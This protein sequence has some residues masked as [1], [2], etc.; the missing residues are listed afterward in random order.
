MDIELM[1]FDG[2]P[3]W[4]RTLGEVREVL[5]ARGLPIDV[6]LTRVTSRTMAKR[7]RFAG[8]PT[9][10]VD[11]RDVEPAGAPAAYGVECRI[12]FVDGRPVGTPPR[13]WLEQAIAGAT[14]T[15]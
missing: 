8:S 14:K 2:C 6:R 9:V 4:Q 13:A 12:Y 7:V 5:A 1:Y 3:N 11:G 10:R 15:A